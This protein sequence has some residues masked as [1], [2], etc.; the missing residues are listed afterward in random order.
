MKVLGKVKEVRG[1]T[2]VVISHRTGACGSCDNCSNPDSCHIHLMF[3]NQKQDV[4]VLAKNPVQA[5]NGDIVE[6][7][8]ATG[9][10]LGISAVIFV[11]PVILCIASHVFFEKLLRFASLANLMLVVTFAVSFLICIY[12]INRYLKKRTMV[13]IVKIVE[14]SRN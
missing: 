10:V 12:I 6:L 14:E 8:S 3:G 2:A 7:E 1:N 11:I 4:E 13:S 9:T 5:K